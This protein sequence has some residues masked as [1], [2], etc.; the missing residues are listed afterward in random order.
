MI[1]EKPLKC[2]KCESGEINEKY[3]PYGLIWECNNP[4]CVWWGSAP[5]NEIQKIMSLDDKV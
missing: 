1:E 2:P 3:M 5:C 4:Q